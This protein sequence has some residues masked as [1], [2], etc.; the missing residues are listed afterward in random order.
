MS[1]LLCLIATLGT[2]VGNGN[3]NN[4]ELCL[5][6]RLVVPVKGAVK[7]SISIC[8]PTAKVPLVKMVGKINFGFNS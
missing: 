7:S 5:H 1:P 2:I 4:D 3:K 6:I 8:F